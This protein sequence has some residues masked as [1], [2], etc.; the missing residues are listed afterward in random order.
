MPNYKESNVTGEV[1]TWRAMR[2]GIADNI[3]G[4]APSFTM[5]EVDRTSLND[6]L[7]SEKVTNRQLR[8]TSEDP[9]LKV[10]HIDP[11]TYEQ[12]LDAEGE[13]IE[14]QYFTAQQFAYFT[15][16]VYIAAAK[17]KDIEEAQIIPE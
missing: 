7:I 12:V 15:A 10:P 11:L 5:M 17:A 9:N 3:Y 6:E 13:P 14:G 1:K 4:L 8:M 2:Q 16:C